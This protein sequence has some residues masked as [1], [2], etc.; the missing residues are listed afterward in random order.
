MPSSRRNP[1]DGV[2]DYVSELGRLRSLGVHG[3]GLD[4]AEAAERTHASAWL[5]ATDILA[6][7]DDLL[8]RVEL[9]GVDPTDVDLHLH[10]GSLTVSG[11]RTAD[12]GDDDEFY[13]RERPHGAFRRVVSLPEGTEAADLEASFRAGL[14]EVTVRGG[15]RP[16]ETT[17]IDLADRSAEE[18]SRPVEPR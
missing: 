11:S 12:G 17:R 4:H 13:V 14:V 10:H 1:F 9:A 3:H 2:T 7:G 18:T 15:A 8:I 6:R 5:P 16:R